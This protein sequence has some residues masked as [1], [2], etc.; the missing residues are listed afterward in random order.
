MRI[1]DLGEPDSIDREV[2]PGTESKEREN[3]G[4]G[5]KSGVHRRETFQ[6]LG[7]RGG[8]DE[9]FYTRAQYVLRRWK[10]KGGPSFQFTN[11][12]FRSCYHQI[13]HGCGSI[14][15][16]HKLRNHSPL[17]TIHPTERTM[18]YG[19]NPYSFPLNVA[20]IVLFVILH[21]N[22]QPSER[23]NSETTTH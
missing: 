1:A 4:N 16:Q 8:R 23:P 14:R 5:E 17:L 12:H 18:I 10:T 6:T 21:C 15:Q 22:K 13:S 11:V 20:S 2:S 7:T 3:E 9:T 19:H